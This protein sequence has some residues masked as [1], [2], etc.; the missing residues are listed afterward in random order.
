LLVTT[1]SNTGYN[2]LPANDLAYDS[3]IYYL[4]CTGRKFAP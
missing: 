1:A 4:S 3:S 2:S